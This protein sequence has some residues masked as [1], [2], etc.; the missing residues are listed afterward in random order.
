MT[1]ETMKVIIHISLSLQ[2]FPEKAKTR[3]KDTILLR[4]IQMQKI[5]NRKDH[6]VAD[7]RIEEDIERRME[8]MVK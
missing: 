5:L 1:V 8:E 6:R 2:N 7:E 4:K 3:R